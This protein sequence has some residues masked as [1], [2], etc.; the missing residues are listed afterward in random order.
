MAVDQRMTEDPKKVLH[1][2]NT[3]EKLKSVL[4]HS[5][6]SSG[7]QESVAEHSW[8]LALIALTLESEFSNIDINKVIR[9]LLVHDLGEIICGD[10]PVFPPRP[11]N[12]KAAKERD[13]MHVLTKELSEEKKKE[14]IGLWEEYESCST[15][16][17]RLAKTIDKIEALIQHNECDPS[18]LEEGEAEFNLNFAKHHTDSFEF[19]KKLRELVDKE[20]KKRVLK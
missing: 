20:T 1:F 18:L 12:D 10:V 17:A 5:Y 14:I 4:R 7:R 13:A 19:I 16:E 9:I 2:F 6:L 3:A 11:R 8:R 15:N